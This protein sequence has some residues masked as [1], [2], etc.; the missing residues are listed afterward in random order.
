MEHKNTRTELDGLIRSSM[1]IADAPSQ[2]L[3]DSLAQSLYRQEAALKRREPMNAIPLWYVPMLLNLVT[4]G[5][6]AVLSLIVI[7]NPY[8]AKFAAGLCLYAGVAGILITLI[9]VKRTNLKE[10]ITVRIQKRGVAA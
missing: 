8:L 10:D 2:E 5:M 4:F 3:N 7:S 9:G 6:F 1:E